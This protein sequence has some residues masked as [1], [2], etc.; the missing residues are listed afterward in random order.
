[1][2]TVKELAELFGISRQAMRKHVDNLEP[3]YLAKN[4]QGYKTVLWLGVLH[5]ADKLG[6]PELLESFEIPD[7]ASSDSIE[8]K[9]LAQLQQKDA[10]IDQ[11][12][13][14]LAQQQKLLD[15]QQQLTLQANKQILLLT[16][17]ERFSGD[18][19]KENQ[20]NKSKRIRSVMRAPRNTKEK[21]LL[22]MKSCDRNKKDRRSGGTF[23]VNPKIA[24]KG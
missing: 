19:N 5:L 20:I 6:R 16:P 14:L 8:T 7:T 3:T 21:L 9:L 23:S 24:L 4:S 13:S 12:Q 1:M 17:Q 18:L 10:Q 2:L 11:L 15:Q 22:K